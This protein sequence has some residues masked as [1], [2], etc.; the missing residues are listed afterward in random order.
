MRRKPTENLTN[1]EIAAVSGTGATPKLSHRDYKS[2]S[3]TDMSHV[4]C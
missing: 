4:E 3:P 2:G 1:I